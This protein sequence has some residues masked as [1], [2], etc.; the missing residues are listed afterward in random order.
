MQLCDAQLV[1]QSNRR[2]LG[3]FAYLMR[4]IKRDPWLLKR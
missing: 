2:S 3:F 4:L 1:P